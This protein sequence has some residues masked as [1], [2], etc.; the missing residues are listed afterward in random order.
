MT[1]F[2]QIIQTQL[3]DQSWEN[4]AR[5]R[6]TSGATAAFF[7]EEFA[8]IAAAKAIC[9][10]CDVLAQ[11]LEQAIVRAEPCGVWG[12]QLFV[13]GE[14]VTQK[15]RRGRP[16]KV[17]KPEEQLPVVAI[18]EHLKELVASKP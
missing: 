9:S 3:A 11:C 18:P 8:D 7:S 12:G 2:N 6:Q 14:I 16:S 4:E 15:R 1:F 17:P 13:N 10:D 5:C